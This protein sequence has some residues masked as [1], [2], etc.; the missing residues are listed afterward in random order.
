[1]LRPLAVSAASLLLVLVACG[2]DETGAADGTSSGSSGTSGSSGSSGTSGT[3]VTS[4]SSG[5]SANPFS[6]APQSGIATYYDA[7]GASAWNCSFPVKDGPLDVTA[8]NF[9][10]YAKSASCGACMKVTGPKGSVTVRVV[11]SCPGCDAHHLDL[12]EEAFA[13]IADLKAGRVNIT[14]QGIA[15]DVAGN[16]SYHYKEGSSKFWTA[17]QIRNH[18][19]PVTKVEYKKSG[20]YVEM[21]RSD[22]N[23]FIDA[24]GAGDQPSGLAIRITAVDGQTVEDTI[25]GAITADKVTAGNVQFK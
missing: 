1:M 24:K 10:E 7:R 11:D 6:T 22:Y 2:G 4:G 8:L 15:C 21:T 18:R 25:P 14:Y 23:Y 19:L 13:K 9:P 16:L 3:S 20:A 5:S 12:S 17:I